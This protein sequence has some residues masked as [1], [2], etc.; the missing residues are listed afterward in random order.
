[1]EKALALADQHDVRCR[2]DEEM[3]AEDPAYAARWVAALTRFAALKASIVDEAADEDLETMDVRAF[4]NANILARVT[5]KLHEGYDFGPDEA[6]VAAARA[7]REASRD[8]RVARAWEAKKK[9]VAA[10]E[11]AAVSSSDYYVLDA[12]L[13]NTAEGTSVLLYAREVATGGASALLVVPYDDYFFIE[14]AAAEDVRGLNGFGGWVARNDEPAA[15]P[16]LR[17]ITAKTHVK[18]VTA[19]TDL[20]SVYGYQPAPQAMLEVHTSSPKMTRAFTSSLAKKHP[21]WRFYEADTDYLTKFMAGL[22][23]GAGSVVRVTGSAAASNDLSTCATRVDVSAI[24]RVVDGAPVFSPRILYF[25]IECLSLNPDVFPSAE[26][27]PVIQISY[28]VGDAR[29]VL[30]LRETPGY[31]SYATE[32]QLLVRFAQI[33]RASDPDALCGFNSNAFDLPYIL[34]RMRVLGLG[35]YAELSRRRGFRVTYSK[36]QRSSK[37]AGTRDIVRVRA[38]GRTM[39]DLFDVIKNDVTKKLRSYSLKAICEAYLPDGANKE[40][41]RYR[42]IPALFATPEG[43]ARI[44]SYCMRDTDL[45]VELDRRL[46]LA[47]NTWGMAAVLGTT[48]EVTLSRGLVF[49]LMCKL[50]QYTL[51]SGYLIPAFRGGQR[52]TFDG[53]YQGAFVLD[54]EVGFHEDPVVVLD[55]A[56]LYPAIMIGWNLSYDTI[57]LDAAWAA[58][59][60]DAVETHCGV[61]F[62]TRAT[63]RGIIPRLQEELAAERAAAKRR[64]AAAATPEE[65]AVYD[66]LQLANKVIM[67]SLYGMLGSPNASV[68]CVEIAKTITGL[69]RDNLLAA[70]AFVE[71]EY[72]AITGEARPAVV[73]YGDTDSI[74]IKMPGVTRARAIDLGKMLEKRV[75]AALFADRPPMNM[76]YEKVFHPFLITRRKGYCGTKYE[77]D[78]AK[79]AV[80]AMGFQI[81][82]RD[83]AVLCVRAMQGFFDCVFRDLDKAA[84][85]ASVS[86]IIA[87]LFAGRL[88]LSDFVLSKKIAKSSYAVEPPHV[89]AWKRMRARVGAEEAPSVGE[90]FEYVVTY[91]AG[92]MKEGVID[93]PLAEAQNGA[94]RV[95]KDY[96]F[97]TFIDNPL[98]APMTHV[99]GAAEAARILDP[100][101]YPRAETAAAA[102]GNLLAAWG[103]T[104]EVKKRIKVNT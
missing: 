5:E 91:A 73:I 64:K 60:P 19:R 21:A 90:R 31:E 56:S 8:A 34:D 81:V 22:G 18:K 67:N 77:H 15:F 26:A 11:S 51:R 104:G 95:D 35:R 61:P 20:K 100:K 76:E 102:P 37:Q 27:C 93:L 49:K 55:F 86:A 88:P 63:H 4:A 43:R 94:T 44:A 97:K 52:P 59:H 71:A 69:G 14:G 103:V 72:G 50:K 23:I 48:A 101:R 46:M 6:Q 41:L 29:G 62:V 33:V 83:A 17:P 89:V 38:P 75:Q 82:R 13:E 40:D 47:A 12:D 2:I 87:D 98:R 80:T 28:R 7:M 1:M 68:P 42:D 9:A 25:D 74:F 96:Y 45:L 70:K 66:G 53:T 32:E 57:V 99:L 54:P 36:Q 39:F 58:A 3:L 78:P 92:L 79:G 10:A 65:A 24:E 16:P 30:C 84:G 85:G